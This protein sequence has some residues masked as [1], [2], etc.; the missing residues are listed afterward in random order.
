[1]STP[2]P[3]PSKAAIRAL[4]GLALG[5]SCAL[6]LVVEDRRRRI[7]TLRTAIDN[8]KKLRTSRKY[9]GAA[10]AVSYAGDD[11]VVLS[12][13][14]LHWHYHNASSQI[15]QEP[16]IT[17]LRSSVIAE[18]N[19][20]IRN[21]A[22]GPPATPIAPDKNSVEPRTRTSRTSSSLLP[23]VAPTAALPKLRDSG[24]WAQT[25]ALASRP[26]QRPKIAELFDLPI[27]TINKRLDE[28]GALATFTAA[29]LSA[30]QGKGAFRRKLDK[31][32]LDISQ[33][34]CIRCQEKG[35]LQEAQDILVAT[36]R[37][38]EVDE[39]RYY[40]HEPFPIMESIL[41]TI[42]IDRDSA[43]KRL[44]LVAQ[45]F[46]AKFND[47]PRLHAD[48]VLHVGKSLIS[49]LIRFNQ[50]QIVH[51]VYWRVLGQQAH[52]EEFTAWF[53]QS[54]YEYSDYKSVIK[55]FRVN[56]S[57]MSPDISCFDATV[58]L[59]LA[60]VEAMRG[61]H[62]EQVARALSKLC[63]TTG[64]Q[65]Q[66]SWLSQLL[67]SHWSRHKD[68]EMSQC[69]FDEFVSSGLMDQI[70][71]RE[72]VYQ[73]MVKLAVLAEDKQV[74]QRYYQETISLAPRMVNNVWLNGYMT[75]MKAKDN[76]WDDVFT[77]FSNMKRYSKSQMEAYDQ[78]FVA[79]LKVFADR[80][81]ITQVE[82]FIKL[83][84]AE[85][86]VRFH[87]YIV[88]F[89]ANKYG[90]IH[91]HEGFIGWLGYCSSQGFAP[92]PGF[93]NAILHNF[94]KQ[95][96][97]PYWILRKLYCAIRE[98]DP[99]S[100]DK[101]TT[102]IMH[103]AAMEEG[104]Y[105][106]AN[107]NQRLGMLGAAPSKLPYFFKSANER[108]VLHAMSEE[109]VRRRPA[110]AVT[111]YKRAVRF[112]MP[113]CPKCLRVAVEAALQQ[114]DNIGTAVGFISEMHE[115]G[116]DV[117]SAVGTLIKAQIHQF[118]GSFE[119]VM[120]NLQMLITRFEASGVLIDASVLTQ[121]AVMSAQFKQFDRTIHLCKLAM[122]KSGATNP[123]FSRQSL[124]AL[125]MAYWQ[126]LDTDGMRWLVESLLS[127]PLAADKKALKL[128]KD[129]RK[130]MADWKQSTRVLEIIEILKNGIDHLKQRREIEIKVGSMMYKETLRIISTAAGA[131]GDGQREQRYR[132]GNDTSIK[133]IHRTLTS[134][135]RSQAP[136]E[137][138][139]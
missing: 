126:T 91:D 16:R 11:A 82:D 24:G 26:A 73:I 1:M 38:G 133:E 92:D 41:R 48:E 50:I 78:T 8:K 58:E 72:E 33:A 31:S 63:S 70:D 104:N 30:G 71:D 136:V 83:Y 12:G 64:L 9:H 124:R 7:S 4:R 85:M 89:V 43:A 53:L 107:M 66:T 139:G 22:A 10:E 86:D 99:N 17:S 80:H 119:E 18:T 122:E 76:A 87:R 105:S 118:R 109:V 111:I 20:T 110:K 34:L 121:A 59:V 77:D 32:W 51:Q 35:L 97:F 120:G 128:L 54:L 95:W 27:A 52:P 79:V 36:V 2:V 102:R 23:R 44:H 68:L 60:S 129:T 13:D 125:L 101:V 25:P 37:S 123:C 134:E 69:F 132:D 65:P 84:K 115:K 62:A 94:R 138:Y 46:L 112:G 67:Q 21:E 98:L 45:L 15:S 61:A 3:V 130:H 113:W 137:A 39:V 90:Q 100:V 108:D 42:D 96:N 75:L 56:F 49:Q 106:G 103:S 28:P 74:A 114:G 116:H 47:K 55:Y 117:S 57:K 29:F 127:S 5:T 88:T 14:E 135:T 131:S 19:R 81:I 93:T 6:G 40:A